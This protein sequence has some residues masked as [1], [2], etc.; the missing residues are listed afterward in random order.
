MASQNSGDLDTRTRTLALELWEQA[1][2]PDGQDL[3]FWER[4]KQMQMLSA[5]A[6]PEGLPEAESDVLTA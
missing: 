4:A 1:G 6:T 2:K 5:E 3:A